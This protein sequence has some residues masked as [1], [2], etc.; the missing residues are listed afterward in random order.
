Y[1]MTG[2]RLG[3]ATGPKHVIDAMTGYQSQSVSC[4]SATSQYAALHA[5]KNS[6]PDVR[7]T[8]E[9]LKQRRDFIMGELEKIDGIKAF[10]PEG[11][12]YIWM[13]VSRFIGRK[14]RGKVMHG[15]ADLSAA[16]IDNHLVAVVPGVEFGIEGY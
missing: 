15:S 8:V 7:K 9:L 13:D 5:I 14:Y 3:W 11:A 1:A 2:W 16:L 10:K 6:R 4:A 12:F